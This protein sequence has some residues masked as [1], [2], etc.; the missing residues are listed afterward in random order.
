MR[1][2]EVLCLLLSNGSTEDIVMTDNNE[3]LW[4]TTQ[5]GVPILAPQE[6]VKLY[7]NAKYIIANKYHAKDIK[8]Q[9]IELGISQECILEYNPSRM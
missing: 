5:A 6:C 3:A 1:G 4:N 2:H 7:R 8:Q 9:L